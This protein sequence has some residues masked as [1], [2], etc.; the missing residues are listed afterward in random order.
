MLTP[1]IIK[2]GC[3]LISF[4]SVLSDKKA[5]AP[6]GE[7]IAK[8]LNYTLSL[9]KKFGFDVIN[10]DDYAGEISVGK[11]EEIGIMGHIDVVPVGDGW[12]TDPFT[13]TK[14][15]GLFFGR[16]LMDDK[17]PLL[18][19]LYALKQL[20]EENI[21]FNKKI[22]LFVGCDEESGWRDLDYLNSKTTL[23]EYGFS[24]DGDFPVS[25][26]EKGI[27]IVEFSIPLIKG[28]SYIKG[29]TVINAVCDYVKCKTDTVDISLLEK[30]F[31]RNSY[32][33]DCSAHTFCFLV[34]SWWLYLC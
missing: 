10:Y 33:C 32:I 23:P 11:G 25:Y 34:W 28:L 27:A 31:N 21:P 7:E 19:C 9:G 16:G 30:L 22:R 29:G 2:S 26:A 4:K 20:K 3:S 17:A 13:L 24:P 18:L 14:K 1:A 6:F 15:D 5:N 8:A 12:N